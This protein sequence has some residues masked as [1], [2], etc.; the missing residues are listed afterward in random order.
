MNSRK[1]RTEAVVVLIA[2]IYE[3]SAALRSCRRVHYRIHE[4]TAAVVVAVLV[5]GEVEDV[6]AGLVVARADLQRGRI[7]EKCKRK[8]RYG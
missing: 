5:P 3:R 4:N 6:A 1:R 8:I 7:S 2:H